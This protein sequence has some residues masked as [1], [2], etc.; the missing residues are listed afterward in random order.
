MQR[1]HGYILNG[2]VSYLHTA[3]PTFNIAAVTSSRQF[4]GDLISSGF[5]PHISRTKIRRFSTFA[6]WLVKYLHAQA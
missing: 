3:T 4:V 1:A 6:I 2:L 5:E